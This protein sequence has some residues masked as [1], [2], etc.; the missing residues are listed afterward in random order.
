[1]YLRC[2]NWRHSITTHSTGARIARLSYARLGFNGG[3]SRPVNSG[4]PS[5]RRNFKIISFAVR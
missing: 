1:M 4:V 5:A 2:V 3:S